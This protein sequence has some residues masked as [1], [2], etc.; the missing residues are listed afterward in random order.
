[1][2]ACSPFCAL[3]PD[4]EETYSFCQSP[5]SARGQVR[6]ARVALRL[7]ASGL[8][9]QADSHMACHAHLFGLVASDVVELV[10]SKHYR[11]IRLTAIAYDEGKCELLQQACQP[12]I[13]ASRQSNCPRHCAMPIAENLAGDRA[14]DKQACSA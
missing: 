2:A 6:C 4:L 12:P 8:L 14:A 7:A 5:A 11:H 9:Q 3:F 10:T 13:Y 1:M